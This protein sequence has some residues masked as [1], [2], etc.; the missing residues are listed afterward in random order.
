M[1]TARV[2]LRG[3]GP[4]L[5]TSITRFHVLPTANVQ[6]QITTRR[7]K[8]DGVVAVNGNENF[9]PD[10]VSVSNSERAKLISF[11]DFENAFKV[12]TTSEIIR[13]IA[14]YK[15]CSF[16]FLVERNK[17]VASY[18]C[19]SFGAQHSQCI[20]SPQL[21][22][23]HCLVEQSSVATSIISVQDHPKN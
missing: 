5:Q 3:I 22:L 23:G 11:T 4:P 8:S 19:M 12:K 13:A 15:I 20:I 21:Y 2:F 9:F 16:D 10:W 6:K 1:G 7:Q 14:V 18:L 17:E